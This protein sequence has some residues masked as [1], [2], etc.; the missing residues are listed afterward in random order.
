MEKFVIAKLFIKT[1]ATAD[2][3][4]ALEALAVVTRKEPGCI[5]YTWYAEPLEAGVFMLIEHYRDKA[6]LQHHFRQTYLAD[7]IKKMDTWKI[8]DPEVHFLSAEPDALK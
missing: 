6:G 4:H 8:K 5:S 7:F 1:S 2:F 3:H